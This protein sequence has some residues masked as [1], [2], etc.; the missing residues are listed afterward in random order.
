MARSSHG[1]R[2]VTTWAVAQKP[3]PT[4]R[5]VRLG[6]PANDNFRRPRALLNMFIVGLAAALAVLAAANWNL[7]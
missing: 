7:F 4:P 2:S 6:R 1:Q 3:R 5:V